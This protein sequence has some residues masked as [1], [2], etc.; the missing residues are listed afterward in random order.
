M[1]RRGFTL[2]ETMLYIVIV[3]MVLGAISIFLL[4]V[5]GAREKTRVISEVV[6][7]GSFI[8]ERL[9]EAVR[10]ASAVRVAESTFGTD[11]GVLSLTMVN[12][13]RSPTVFSLT[14]DDG[15]FQLSETGAP[16]VAITPANVQV[17]NLVF[18]NLTTPSDV[19]IIQVQF[20]L[21][22]SSASGNRTFA[23]DQAF[24]TTL[25]VPLD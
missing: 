14:A 18:T 21:S 6:A 23:Y 5:L 8:Q 3:A 2:I 7:S 17:T 24:Q 22:V 10:H 16:A 19:G 1:D 20:T 4:Q 12:S 25:R 9:F 11:P 15:Q 13:A